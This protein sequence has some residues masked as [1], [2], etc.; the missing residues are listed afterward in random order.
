MLVVA[1]AEPD[2][3]EPPLQALTERMRGRWIVDG[4]F[5]WDPAA[6]RDAGWIPL[7]RQTP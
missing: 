7:G 5:T 3:A 2:W 1:T 6:L 4:S